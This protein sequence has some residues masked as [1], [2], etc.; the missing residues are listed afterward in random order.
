MELGKLVGLGNTASVYEWDENKVIKL[1]IKDYPKEFI[2]REYHNAVSI[3]EM[4]F[5]KP[6]AYEILHIDG[7]WGI[8]Y[9]QLEGESL[10]EWLMRTGDIKRCAAIMADLHKAVL[11]NKTNNVPD[12]KEFLKNLI[13]YNDTALNKEKKEE[14]LLLL[15][16]LPDG[17]TLCHG[18]FHPGNIIINGDTAM[19]IDFMNIC[20]GDYLYDVAR[21]VFLVEYTPVPDINE[22]IEKLLYLKKTLADLYLIEMDVKRESISDFLTVIEEA[23]KGEC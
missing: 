3:N 12:Y 18:D 19:V 1:F 22:D 21:T 11:R 4:N 13:L 15:S 16:K 9:D 6:K 8:L 10:L 20:H 14:I 23:R 17:D 7:R 2:E 5:I